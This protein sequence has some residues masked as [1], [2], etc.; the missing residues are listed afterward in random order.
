[1]TTTTAFSTAE[2]AQAY[3][4][5]HD[6]RVKELYRTALPALRDLERDQLARQ[7]LRRVFGGPVSKDELVS[8]ILATEYPAERLNEAGHVLY[9]KLGETWSACNFCHPHQGSTC[10]CDLR[11]QS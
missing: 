1:M 6:A 2:S 5:A 4:Q 8:A 7:G 3:R 10:E 9:H 11:G